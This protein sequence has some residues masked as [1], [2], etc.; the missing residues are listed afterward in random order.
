MYQNLKFSLNTDFSNLTITNTNNLNVEN[1]YINNSTNVNNKF[2]INNDLSCN[3][4]LN[5]SLKRKCS[6]SFSSIFLPC[7][8]ST[9]FSSG[10]EFF[11]I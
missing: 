5:K 4:N 1:L 3:G 11:I 8:K 6:M 10:I 2:F 9:D 7:F